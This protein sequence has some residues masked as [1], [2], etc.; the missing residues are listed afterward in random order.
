MDPLLTANVKRYVGQ[1]KMTVGKVENYSPVQQPT[2]NQSSLIFHRQR[3][4]TDDKC[5]FN[6]F[7][8]KL[9]TQFVRADVMGKGFKGPTIARQTCN[10]PLMATM[11]N[12][13]A[14]LELGSYLF[15]YRNNPQ[16]DANRT[17]NG[18]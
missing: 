15:S 4:Q 12:F 18:A 8:C 1:S 14:N 16:I 3:C 10:K 13:N 6:R 2:H 7:S 11:L 5:I 17:S 9:G